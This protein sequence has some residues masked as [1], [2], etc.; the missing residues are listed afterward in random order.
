MNSKDNIVVAPSL[1]SA[2][3]SAMGE[4]VKKIEESGADWVHMDI[5]DGVFV[6]TLTFGPKMVA[7]LRKKTKLPMDVHLMVVN[8]EKY[9]KPFI[10]AGA[11][12]ITFHLEAEVHSHRLLQNIL[13]LGIKAGISIVPSTPAL[14]LGEILDMLDIILIM[15][16]NPGFGGQKLISRS[17]EKIS[18]L[19]AMK[20]EKGFRYRIAVDGG[21]DKTT[22]QSLRG[23]GAEI[24]V[25]GSAFFG[26]ADP[27]ADVMYLRGNNFV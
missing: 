19:A 4:A 20:R 10:E 15:T 1:L 17:L 6:P 3:F 21:V 13:G 16:V 26:S 18:Y 14:L 23:A 2:D 12:H 8:P 5:M 24:L 22:V 7:D 27:A 25:T 9:I 11:D